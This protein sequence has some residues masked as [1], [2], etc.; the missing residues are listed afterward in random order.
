MNDEET[1][2]LRRSLPAGVESEIT[3]IRFWQD[4]DYE[5][6]GGHRARR[7]LIVW[8]GDATESEA[9]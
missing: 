4:Q 6:R 7:A 5:D 1:E 8:L 2:A 9:R 3:A